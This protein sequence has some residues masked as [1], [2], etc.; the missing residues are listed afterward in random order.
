MNKFF[1]FLKRKSVWITVLTIAAAAA[2]YFFWRGAPAEPQF[3]EVKRGKVVQ[4]VSV[5]GR[6]KSVKA[7][8]LGFEQ[9]GKVV[10]VAADVGERVRA[11]EILAQLDSE[12]ALAELERARAAVEV[13]QARLEELRRGTR[14]EEIAVALAKY[15]S[16]MQALDNAD[17]T[18]ADK[19]IDAYAKADDAVR[20]RT[21]PIFT[22]PRSTNPRFNFILANPTLAS[23]LEQARVAQERTLS[24]W[25]SELAILRRGAEPLPFLVPAQENLRL[26]SAFLDMAA[27]AVN[28]LTP[29]DTLS[30]A[31][32]DTYRSN[33]SAGRVS[34]NAAAIGLSV[35]QEARANAESAVTIAGEELM[36]KR[37]GATA[38]AV[39]SQQAQVR[40]AEASARALEARLSKYILRS[41]IAGIVTK[42]TIEAGEL[43]GANVA[44]MSVISAHQFEIEAKVPEVDIAKLRTGQTARVTLDAYSSDTAFN[45]RVGK[46][47]PGETIIDGVPTYL[48]TFAFDEVDERIRSGMTANIN[49]DTAVKEN[50]LILPQRAIGVRDGARVVRVL[51]G[52]VIRVVR[53]QTGLRGVDGSVEMPSGVSEGDRVLIPE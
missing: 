19:I 46:I 12:T 3:V 33:V 13:Q 2:G 14:S 41:P 32:I 26:S 24:E 15:D 52:N 7:V 23:K 11:G 28:A 42:R 8:Q 34:V 22:D 53:V 1:A 38:E 29:T 10:R 31:A 18:L 35:A 47:E 6:T 20:Y 49:I 21:D 36:L 39:G 51:D 50:V 4:Q 9:N 44:V 48:A 43:V 40:E 5:T 45:V 37:A 16:A 27:A 25:G 30:Q 17:K